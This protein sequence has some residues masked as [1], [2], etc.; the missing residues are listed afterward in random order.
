MAL[1]PPGEADLISV[2]AAPGPPALAWAGSEAP[3]V[4]RMAMITNILDPVDG[5]S[6][7]GEVTAIRVEDGLVVLDVEGTSVPLPLITAVL[8]Y[9]PEEQEDGA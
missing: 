7:G 3:Q 2:M 9:A 6:R 5:S 4:W 1:P 8:G